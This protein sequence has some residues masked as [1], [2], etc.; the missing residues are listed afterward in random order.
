LN[1]KGDEDAEDE[2]F[3]G[4]EEDEEEHTE[5]VEGEEIARSTGDIRFNDD[6]EPEASETPFTK[7]K[8]TQNKEGLQE[9]TRRSRA[10]SSAKLTGGINNLHDVLRTGES[11][12]VQ[13]TTSSAVPIS[14]DNVV[15]APIRGSNHGTETGQVI[16]N[17]LVAIRANATGEQVEHMVPNADQRDAV[18]RARPHQSGGVR[19]EDEIVV[20]N[21][22]KPG[23]KSNGSVVD[24]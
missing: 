10:S 17:D 2:S 13:S 18:E 14:H 21:V 3:D 11:F 20:A 5:Q 24:P 12:N 6:E 4:D 8:Q 9:D 16:S 19:D 22:L 15:S 1:D 23:P 7:L